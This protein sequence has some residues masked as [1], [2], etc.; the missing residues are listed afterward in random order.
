MVGHPLALLLVDER[1]L[2]VED[3]RVVRCDRH[4]AVRLGGHRARAARVGCSLTGGDPFA[5]VPV[6]GGGRW[7]VRRSSDE[8]VGVVQVSKREG[9][10]KENG[11]VTGEQGNRLK[12]QCVEVGEEDG[13]VFWV[14]EMSAWR[15]CG[16]REIWTA[17][18][19]DG[20]RVARSRRLK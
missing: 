10:R 20:G 8:P 17:W 3:D 15:R 13:Q 6:V 5:A 19:T 18:R 9:E 1:L 12:V 4:R 2:E 16:L 14:I 7:S 11:R